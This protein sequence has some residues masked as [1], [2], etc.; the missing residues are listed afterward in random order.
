MIFCFS[1]EVM[2]LWNFAFGIKVLVCV[3]ASTFISRTDLLVYELLHLDFQMKLV[4]CFVFGI[5]VLMNFEVWAF[6]FGT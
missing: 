3:E 5:K 1:N 2:S 6:D 4:C